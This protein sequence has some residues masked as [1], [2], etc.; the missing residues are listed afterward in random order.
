[1][2][3]RKKQ[4]KILILDIESSFSQLAV[5]TLKPQWHNHSNILD[6]WWI[7][8]AAWKWLGD[9]KIHSVKTYRKGCDKS[10]VT[11]LKKLLE[12]ADVVVGHNTDRFDLKKINARL[13]YHG[14]KP[15]VIPQSVDTLK[16]ARKH[17]MLTSNKLDYIANY[18][19]VGGK[20][21]TRPNLWMRTLKGDKKAIDEMVK[22]NKQDIVIQE[23]VFLK[24]RPFTALPN[25]NAWSDR[26][27][28]VCKSCGSDKLKSHG[29]VRTKTSAYR[30]FMC[31]RC[32][33]VTRSRKAEETF[34]GR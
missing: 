32:G 34:D 24:L 7:H 19:G 8:C 33:T 2:K 12:Q 23:K 18:L 20:M 28:L 22:Y 31:L 16:V 26:Q 30:R 11:K 4:P 27:G 9:D 3:T 15:L 1:M 14:L 17:F 10:I 13:L 29:I 5:F 21:T 6:E 25:M